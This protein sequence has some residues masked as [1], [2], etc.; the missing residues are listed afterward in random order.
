MEEEMVYPKLK[1]QNNHIL[2]TSK[3]VGSTIDLSESSMNNLLKVNQTVLATGPNVP[4]IIKPG[5]V[6][7]LD[8]AKLMAKADSSK[9]QVYLR[10]IPYNKKTG[11]VIHDD[12]QKSTLDDDIQHAVLITYYEILAVL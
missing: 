9:K 5:S 3:K 12:N 2:I 8:M 4:E 6:I 1:L 11:E 10:S 7:Y